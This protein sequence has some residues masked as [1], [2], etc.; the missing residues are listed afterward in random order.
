MNAES[1]RKRA[2]FLHEV[3]DMAVAV[4]KM[5]AEFSQTGQASP[6]VVGNFSLSASM[7]DFLFQILWEILD[8]DH[9]S[10]ICF[11]IQMED[12]G[13]W[14]VYTGLIIFYAVWWFSF[15]RRNRKK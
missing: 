8:V 11:V 6:V 14:L 9:H 10:Q 5:L 13:R 2:P 3:R 12:L 1:S 7:G 4:F 15:Q